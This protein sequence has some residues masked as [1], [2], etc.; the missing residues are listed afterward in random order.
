MVLNPRNFDVSYM[1][2]CVIWLTPELFALKMYHFSRPRN[3]VY[4]P[5][6]L[7][8]L[9]ND[10][11]SFVHIENSVSYRLTYSQG[12]VELQE[13]ERDDRFE[14]HHGE[15]HRLSDMSWRKLSELDSFNDWYEQTPIS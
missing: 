6:V 14:S 9:G 2:D 4:L 11:Y 5:F 8:D 3:R 13:Y 7:V 1:D 15:R 10:R 12:V